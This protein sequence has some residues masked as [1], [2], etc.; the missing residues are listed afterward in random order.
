MGGHGRWM[1]DEAEALAGEAGTEGGV[2]GEAIDAEAH[3][4]VR[5]KVGRKDEWKVAGA[6][7][8]ARTGGWADAITRRLF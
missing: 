6:Q 3:G 7:R 8:K 4:G 2:L 5:R 1:A